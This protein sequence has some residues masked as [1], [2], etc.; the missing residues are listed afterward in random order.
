MTW[1]VEELVAMYLIAHPEEDREFFGDVVLD[2][3]QRAQGVMTP[4]M[5]LRYSKWCLDNGYIDQVAYERSVA[6]WGQVQQQGR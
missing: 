1:S 3:G 5:A 6:L 2:N 4:A